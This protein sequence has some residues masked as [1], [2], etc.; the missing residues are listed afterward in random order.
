MRRIYPHT[1]EFYYHE[2]EGSLKDYIVY[3]RHKRESENVTRKVGF[4]TPGTLNAHQSGVDITF[5]NGGDQCQYRASALIRAFKVKEGSDKNAP[6]IEI[7][8]SKEKDKHVEGRSTYLYDYL[9]TNMEMPVTLEW[10]DDNR[11]DIEP[12]QGY[13]KNVFGYKEGFD[14][15]G[16]P[17]PDK[18]KYPDGKPWAFS[19]SEFPPSLQF[20]KEKDK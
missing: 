20:P 5:E 16:K 3:H 1:V 14:E 9:F 15:K 13:R 8:D 4:F 11:P 6:F 12:F 19:L 7:P 10:E 17:M 18:S 2:E